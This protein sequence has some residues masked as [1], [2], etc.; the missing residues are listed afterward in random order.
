MNP[1]RRF[2]AALSFALLVLPGLGAETVIDQLYGLRNYELADAYWAAG[3]KFT[4]LGQADR[5]AEFQAQAKRIFRGYVPGQAPSFQ[6]LPAAA[7]AEKPAPALPS[8]ASV[9]ESNLQGQKM[10]RLQFQKILRG[11]LTGDASALASALAA[12][13]VLDGQPTAVD[14][15]ALAAFLEAHP[16]EA[17]APDELFDP[18]T[19]EAS[20]GAGQSVVVTFRTVPDAPG[21]LAAVLPFWKAAPKLTFDRVGDTWKLVEVR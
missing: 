13:V 4:D 15:A 1:T 8:A 21:N 9:R 12:T 7:P 10:A 17:G 20:D 2:L 5:G 19:W 16:A 3:Q 14:P 11:Y 6:A 18:A